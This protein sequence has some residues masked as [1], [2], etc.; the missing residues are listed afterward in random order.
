MI[1][2]K[3]YGRK[4]AAPEIHRLEHLPAGIGR[5]LDNAIIITDRSVSSHHAVIEAVEDGLQ[6]RDLNSTNGLHSQSSPDGRT[7]SVIP[8]QQTTSIRVGKIWIEVSNSEEPVEETVRV[9]LAALQRESGWSHA[10][11]WSVSIGLITLALLLRYLDYSILRVSYTTHALLT[12]SLSFV[13]AAFGLAAALAIFS[14]VHLR[15]YQF[16]PLFAVVLGFSII[17]DLHLTLFNLVAFNLNSLIASKVL[18]ELISSLLLFTSCSLLGRVLFPD[19]SARKRTAFILIGLVAISGATYGLRT[20]ND[21]QSAP[22]VDTT[23]AYPLRSFPVADHGF[24]HVLREIDSI[25]QD[26]ETARKE[27]IRKEEERNSEAGR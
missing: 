3:V 26:I 4:N 7:K 21:R 27:A 13:L 9:D 8:L 11:G 1:Y 25:D 15:R 23:I 14:K 20:I 22:D 19:T 2:V 17:G 10:K 5:A 16:Y 12:K 6:I 24:D 18:D